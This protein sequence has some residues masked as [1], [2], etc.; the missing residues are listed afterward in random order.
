MI[1]L[2]AMINTALAV[3]PADYNDENPGALENDH[4]YAESAFLVDMDTGEILLNK[5]SR[6]RMYPAS[7]TKI[8]TLILGLESG[9]P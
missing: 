9:I 7:T 3:T 4:L 6:V 1:A 8:M 5:N 2:C